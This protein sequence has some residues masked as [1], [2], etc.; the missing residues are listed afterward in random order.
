MDWSFLLSHHPPAA[1]GDRCFRV[2]PLRL[3]ARCSGLF[4][5]L[6]AGLLVQRLLPLTASR[7]D[8]PVEL[9]LILPALWDHARSVA[10]PKAGSNPI[11]AFTGQLLG[12]GLSRVAVVGHVEGFGAEAF[13]L[14]VVLSG[15]FVLAPRLW[16]RA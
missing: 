11:R 4:P 2:G 5:A 12:L 1:A 9:A 10:N 16:P 15:C 3:C 7:W 14:P 13:L 6:L 8:L